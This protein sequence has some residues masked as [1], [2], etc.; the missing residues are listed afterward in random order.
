MIVR[1]QMMLVVKEHNSG[2]ETKLEWLK[3]ELQRKYAIQN[4]TLTN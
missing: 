3:M 2:Q 4:G 1:T